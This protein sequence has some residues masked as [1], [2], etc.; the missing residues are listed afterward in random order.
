MCTSQEIRLPCQDQFA[1]KTK[2]DLKPA[3]QNQRCVLRERSSC[4]G[5]Q[6]HSLTQSQIYLRPEIPGVLLMLS[7]YLVEER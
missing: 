3:S 5:K 4:S 1:V 6:S 7:L 2:A